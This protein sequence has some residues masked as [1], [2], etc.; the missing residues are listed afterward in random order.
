MQFASRRRVGHLLLKHCETLGTRLERGPVRSGAEDGLVLIDDLVVEDED[1]AREV[2]FRIEYGPLRIVRRQVF[3]GLPIKGAAVSF[4]VFISELQQP[5][6]MNNSTCNVIGNRDLRLGVANIARG[7]EA[8]FGGSHGLEEIRPPGTLV[9]FAHA[10][11]GWVVPTHIPRH[12]T[13]EHGGR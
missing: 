7:V 10:V 11:K 6:L 3:V 2:P 5:L 4:A 12:A 13:G 1:A 8:G 9:R